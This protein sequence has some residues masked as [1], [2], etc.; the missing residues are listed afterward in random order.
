MLFFLLI[1]S[2]KHLKIRKDCDI[3]YLVPFKEFSLVY[4]LLDVMA[5]S[6]VGIYQRFEETVASV[7]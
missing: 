7:M 4:F 6:L 2:G 1:Y 3:R 5:G